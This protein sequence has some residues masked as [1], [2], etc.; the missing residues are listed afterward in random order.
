MLHFNELRITQDNKYLIIDVSIDS[1]NYYSD[2]ILDS[3]VIDTQDT[4]VPNGPSNKPLYIYEID[5]S[6]VPVYTLPEETNCNPVMVDSLNTQCFTYGEKSK[7]N[8]RIVLSM[9]DFKL[10][11]ENNMFFVYARATGTPRPETPCGLDENQIMGTA[12]NMNLIYKQSLVYMTELIRDC[13]IPQGF[14]DSILR[15]KA[16]ELNIKTGNYIKAIEYWKKFFMNIT[17][18]KPERRCN[19]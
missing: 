9:A 3:I 5:D 11:T 8:A 7:K 17:I 14:T 16:V 13:S 6:L 4:F 10:D 1:L 19:G 2:I 12:L 15:L 18:N